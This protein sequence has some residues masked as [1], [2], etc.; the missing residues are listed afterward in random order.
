MTIAVGDK[1][2]ESTFFVMGENGPEPKT[3]AEIF[4]GKTVVLFAVPGA[5]TPTCHLRHLPGFI[6][7]AEAFKEKGV[8]TIA[9][10]AVNDAFVL[11]AWA[12]ITGGKGK[13]AFLADGNAEFTKK[14]GM[15]FDASG[16][17]L[18]TRS[19]RYAML[20]KDGVVEQLSV[21]DSPGEADVSSA[22]AMLK[23]L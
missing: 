22:E 8:D 12:D 19:K 5:F 6:E 21:E 2:P 4:G 14:I 15:D 20:V 9:C 18:A 13:I 10:L 17:G 16:L 23:V 11:D 3:T 7:H 1:L